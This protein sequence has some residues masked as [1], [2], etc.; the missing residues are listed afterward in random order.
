MGSERKKNSPWFGCHDNKVHMKLLS[1]E[2]WTLRRRHTKINL[3]V[4]KAAQL[5]GLKQ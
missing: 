5:S 2:L 1:K 4:P 3:S